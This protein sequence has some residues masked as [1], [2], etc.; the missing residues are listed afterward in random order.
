LVAGDQK[1]D[2]NADK[3]AD[4]FV[5]LF[6][7]NEG[8]RCLNGANIFTTDMEMEH[9]FKPG[10]NGSVGLVFSQLI[11]E[12]KMKHIMDHVSLGIPDKDDDDNVMWIEAKLKTYEKDY[13]GMALA[14]NN[15]GRNIEKTYNVQAEAKE[16]SVEG[17]EVLRQRLRLSMGLNV[18]YTSTDSVG[19]HSGTNTSLEDHVSPLK[20]VKD[21]F[22]GGDIS[23][24]YGKLTHTGIPIKSV[25]VY[26]LEMTGFKQEMVKN[27]YLPRALNAFGYNNMMDAQYVGDEDNVNAYARLLIDPDFSFTLDN[28]QR[29]NRFDKIGTKNVHFDKLTPDKLVTYIH[30]AYLDGKIAFEIMGPVVQKDHILRAASDEVYTEF[31]AQ[32]NAYVDSTARND[33]GE[34]RPYTKE[35]FKHLLS[36][37]GY[38]KDD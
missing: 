5:M 19:F 23:Y 27:Y 32:N 37:M 7:Q 2:N 3:A 9:L 4:M 15:L 29:Y 36:K 28:P 16:F 30:K 17:A 21:L 10:A 8:A 14:K 11:S 20:V 18:P 25:G 22:A 6:A 34:E 26:D 31:T 12:M 1:F 24:D 38:L 33:E 13:A 35:T